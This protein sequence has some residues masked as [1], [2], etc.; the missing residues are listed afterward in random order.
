M[1]TPGR[2]NTGRSTVWGS[3]A[4][5]A[6]ATLSAGIVGCREAGGVCSV[7]SL[8]RNPREPGVSTKRGLGAGTQ[9]P[10]LEENVLS[11]VGVK[12]SGRK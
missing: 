9:Q 5:D 3:D 2:R 6:L 1:G 10:V 4:S 8:R 7:Q 12:A 11:V